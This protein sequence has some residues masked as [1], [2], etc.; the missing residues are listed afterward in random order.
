MADPTLEIAH[1]LFPAGFAGG[2]LY[3]AA[4]LGTEGLGLAPQFFGLVGNGGANRLDNLALEAPGPE[5]G[6]CQ[7]RQTHDADR[8]IG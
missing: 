5:N 1:Q 6:D 8:D 2:P 3:Q 7:T 4:Q